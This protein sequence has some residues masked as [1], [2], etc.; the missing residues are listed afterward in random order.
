MK[1]TNLFWTILDLLFLALFNA[2]FFV[3]GGVVRPGAI[4]ISY[5]FI[6]F[7]YFMLLLTPFLI[8]Q[9]RSSSIFG[10]SLYSI[11]GL[12]FLVELIIGSAFIIQNYL[13]SK[14]ILLVQLCLAGIY[15]IILISNLIANEHTANAEEARQTKINFIKDCSTKISLLLN[16]LADISIRKKIEKLYDTLNTSPVKSHNEVSQI[17]T[18]ILKVINELSNAVHSINTDSTSKLVDNIIVLINE[19]N[20]KLKRLN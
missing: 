20:M 16:E 11:S 6:H 19:R 4:W 10:F 2:F 15:G 8:R 1:K 9:G 17:E 13:G 12:Y 18:Q 5:G 7:A 3:L 14:I